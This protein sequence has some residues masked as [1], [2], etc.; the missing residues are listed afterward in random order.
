MPDAPRAVTLDLWQTL[1]GETSD[2]EST[3]RRRELRAEGT[4]AVLAGAG[5]PTSRSEF[6]AAS[7]KVGQATGVDHVE[8]RDLTFAGR[9][10][11]LLCFIEAGLPDRLSAEVLAAIEE[12][13][14]KPFL[15]HPPSIYGAAE[16]VLR[17]LAAMDVRIGLIS[18][19]G[20]TSAGVYERFF[21]REGIRRYFHAL[22]F[23]NEM[24]MA[25]PSAAMFEQTL[26]RLG[27]RPE[28]A[29]HVGD[30]LH[31]D[32]AGAKDVGMS[33]VW[34]AGFDDSTPRIP[35]DYTI[36]DISELPG[37]VETWLAS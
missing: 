30:N 36:E 22:A 21:E 1:M 16:G 37:V 27:V 14:D 34:V 8:G 5:R 29:L 28:D 17:A 18:N 11:Q 3:L 25:K 10:R 13:L 19:T 4:L 20:M 6:D 35:P 15:A 24:A 26:E 32:V 9:V 2:R 33:A 7:A 31:T 23:S 12:A